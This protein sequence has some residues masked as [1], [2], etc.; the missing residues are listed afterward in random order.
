MTMKMNIVWI[1]IELQIAAIVALTMPYLWS[2][3]QQ[4][5]IR[6]EKATVIN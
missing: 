2:E 6:R 1:L 5:G 4:E 3:L